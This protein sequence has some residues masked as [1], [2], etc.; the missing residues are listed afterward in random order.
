MARKK[1]DRTTK[2][3]ITWVVAGAV[4]PVAADLTWHVYKEGLNQGRGPT[5][6]D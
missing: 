5:A 6:S 3:A 2:K 4:G 1:M